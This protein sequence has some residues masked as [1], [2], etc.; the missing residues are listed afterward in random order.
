ML[1]YC[2][3]ITTWHLENRKLRGITLI[4][5]SESGWLNFSFGNSINS[6]YSTISKFC[7]SWIPYCSQY[8][9]QSYLHKILKRV[10]WTKSW[11][12]TELTGLTGRPSGFI[13]DWA[14]LSFGWWN[15]Q[16]DPYLQVP[17]LMKY[18]HSG[19]SGLSGRVELNACPPESD[20]PGFIYS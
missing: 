10:I 4:K 15:L 19:W 20:S 12:E 14:I 16:S 7:P 9:L 3:L 13:N 11:V 18:L 6:T 5:Y 2:C 17:V 1:F 8:G